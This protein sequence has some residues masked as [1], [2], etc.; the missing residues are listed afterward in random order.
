MTDT[1]TPSTPETG[2]APM[3]RPY[4]ETVSLELVWAAAYGGY[5]AWLAR[6]SFSQ[7]KGYDGVSAAMADDAA[8]VADDAVAGLL[9]AHPR[10]AR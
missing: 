4:A 2:C 10:G 7:Q 1:K 9:A 3:N 5:V 8:T 6:E